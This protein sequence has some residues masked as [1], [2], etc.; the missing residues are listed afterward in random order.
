MPKYFLRHD[1]WEK[2]FCCIN[3]KEC[4]V[5]DYELTWLDNIYTLKDTDGNVYTCWWYNI[6]PIPLEKEWWFYIMKL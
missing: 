2:V 4:F 3:G 6:A 5:V 1:I